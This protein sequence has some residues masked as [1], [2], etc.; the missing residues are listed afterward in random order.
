MN[1]Q[2]EEQ[3][4]HAPDLQQ[5]PF[6]FDAV[7]DANPDAEQRRQRLKI[8]KHMHEAMPEKPSTHTA[9]PELMLKRTFALRQSITKKVSDQILPDGKP[10]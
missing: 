3:T 4:Q 8:Q 2:E 1:T 10:K 9:H 7:N 5:R 6:C